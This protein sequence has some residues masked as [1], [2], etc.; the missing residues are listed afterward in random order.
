L[1]DAGFVLFLLLLI[2]FIKAVTF[3]AAVVADAD[4]VDFAAGFDVD[5]SKEAALDVAGTAVTVG[6]G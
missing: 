1:A 2:K 6:A 4:V 3:D 5:C